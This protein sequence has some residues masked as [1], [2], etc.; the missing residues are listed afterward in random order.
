VRVCLDR[1]NAQ[2]IRPAVIVRFE[3]SGQLSGVKIDAGGYDDLTCVQDARSHPPQL[4]VSRAASVRC[5]YR[6]GK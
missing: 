6:C 2:Q 3:A 4:T 5:E 1:V